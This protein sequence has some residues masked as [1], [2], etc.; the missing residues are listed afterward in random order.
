MQLIQF[1]PYVSHNIFY[2]NLQIFC[3]F[4]AVCF[5]EPLGRHEKFPDGFLHEKAVLF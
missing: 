2:M 3:A 4:R 5:A 1:K